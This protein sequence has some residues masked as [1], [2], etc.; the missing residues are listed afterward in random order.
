MSG[1]TEPWRRSPMKLT[2]KSHREFTAGLLFLA[3]GATWTALALTYRIGTATAMGPGYF[4]LVVALLLCALGLGS[5]LRAIK[6][7]EP[8][9]LGRWPLAATFF[10][11][12]GVVGFA[13]L[14]ETVGLICAGTTLVL[15]GCYSRV[16]TRS[17]ET[18][19]LTAALVALVSVI[20]VIGLEMPIELY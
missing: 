14:I 12:L 9:E 11:L 16:R 19:L 6:L 1:L 17:L 3:I 7:A 10:I 4:P 20:F 5:M 15:L 13:A 2:I 8:D 18:V